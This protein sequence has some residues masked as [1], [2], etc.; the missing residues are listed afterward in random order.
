MFFA[1]ILRQAEDDARDKEI[2]AIVKS[3][4]VVKRWEEWFDIEEFVKLV[5]PCINVYR[6]NPYRT[7]RNKD[8]QYRGMFDC[9]FHPLLRQRS[10]SL[11]PKASKNNQKLPHTRSSYPQVSNMNS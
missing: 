6:Q 7:E 1:K 9:F 3:V 5:Y 10:S 4:T 8:R 2:A 11:T